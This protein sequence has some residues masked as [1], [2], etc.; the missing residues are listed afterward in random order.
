M[1]KYG[2][3]F[4]GLLI[5]HGLRV[6]CEATANFLSLLSKTYKS[7]AFLMNIS[8]DTAM[9][10]SVVYLSWNLRVTVHS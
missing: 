7:T 8:S 3:L 6:T 2:F 4:K 1:N 5:Q 10:V 9:D